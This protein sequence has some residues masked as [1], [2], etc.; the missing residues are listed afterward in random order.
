[1]TKK[2]YTP[3]QIA[4]RIKNP[5]ETSEEYGQKS[6]LER[7][8]ADLYRG[9]SGEG[10]DS[11]K[12]EKRE[13]NSRIYKLLSMK[14]RRDPLDFEGISKAFNEL[15]KDRPSYFAFLFIFSLL[16]LSPNMTGNAIMD[17]SNSAS[18][19][20]GIIFFVLGLILTYV[21]VKRN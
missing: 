2:E 12:R 14:A 5:Q 19:F 20:L 4:E 15:A 18:N 1:M 7:M 3:E 8:I 11:E 21:W 16:F 13:K 10:G 9:P 6:F 17:L